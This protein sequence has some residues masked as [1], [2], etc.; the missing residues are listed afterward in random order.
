MGID[1]V[2]HVR[3]ATEGALIGRL[4]EH[5]LNPD[6]VILSDDAG[7][8]N[9]LLHALC[10]VHAERIIHKLIPGSD[11]QRDI[12][13]QCRGQIWDLCVVLKTYRESPSE[14]KKI[15]LRQ[16]FDEIFTQQTDY[17]TLNLAL[18]R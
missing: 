2:H 6:L 5:G 10:W 13:A 12:L 9:I 11:A 17:I 7:Q 15:A 3:I 14:E 8:F 4:V 18:K 1:R 16:R